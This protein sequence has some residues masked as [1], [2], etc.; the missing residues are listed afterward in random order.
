MKK[1]Y[2]EISF[3]IVFFPADDIVTGSKAAFPE[4]NFWDNEFD[5]SFGEIFSN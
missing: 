4:D 3:E 2:I 5:D 1:K